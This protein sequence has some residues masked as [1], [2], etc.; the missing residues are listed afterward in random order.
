MIVFTNT[1][2]IICLKFTSPKIPLLFLSVK[3]LCN[4]TISVDKVSIF[5]CASSILD[6]RS[7][8][9]VNVLFVFSKFSSNRSFTL[10]LINLKRYSIFSDCLSKSSLKFLDKEV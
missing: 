3:I 10:S 5:F 7:N 8:T 9:E 2:D 1:L 4:D 6:K